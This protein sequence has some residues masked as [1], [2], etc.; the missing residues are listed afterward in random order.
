MAS[1]NLS[2]CAQI[3]DTFGP[4]AL[5]CRGNF[6]FTLLF[7]ESILTILPLSL[8][9]VFV[10]FR[11]LYLFRKQKKVND[12][13]LVHLKLVG[14]LLELWSFSKYAESSYN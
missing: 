6:D 4:Y 8:L 1:H 9:L 12:G 11:L 2:S 3:D 10:P 14:S 13:P 5:H 7:E